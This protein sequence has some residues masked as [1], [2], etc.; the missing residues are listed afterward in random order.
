M[1]IALC[2]IDTEKMKLQFSG[3]YNPLYLIRNG[4]LVQYKADRQ[5]ISIYIKER[6]FTN[7]D[8]DLQ[9]GDLLYTFSDG[10]SD[11]HGGENDV[12]FMTKN[13]RNLLLEIHKEPFQEQKEI[14]NET[15][16]KWQGNTEQVDDILIF[17][18]K[19]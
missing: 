1:D 8:I 18:V 19:I 15:L 10:F 4:K 16:K 9:K 13:F 3:A 14:L 17:G 5:P 2:V 7:T 11:Q 6:N 12:K